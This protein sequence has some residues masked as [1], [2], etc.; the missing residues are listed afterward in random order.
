MLAIQNIA[1]EFAESSCA[2]QLVDDPEAQKSTIVNTEEAMLLGKQN[3]TLGVQQ[4]NS[5]KLANSI[6][7]SEARNILIV[8]R[9]R[10]GSSFLGSLI[11]Q[12]PGT[13]YSSEPLS[14][15][16]INEIRNSGFPQFG[17]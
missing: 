7:P 2:N 17:C 15:N 8:T 14:W 9:G 3:I 6:P 4:M 11:A 13:F 16:R 10:S 5:Y 1:K 12:H